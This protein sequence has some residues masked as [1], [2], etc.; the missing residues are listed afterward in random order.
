VKPVPRPWTGCCSKRRVSCETR[1]N[2]TDGPDERA[3]EGQKCERKQ[4]NEAWKEETKEV[5]S[6]S[7]VFGMVSAFKSRLND[8]NPNDEFDRNSGS[9]GKSC[10]A[11]IYLAHELN[12]RTRMMNVNRLTYRCGGIRGSFESR[13]TSR[14]ISI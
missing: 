2:Q 3:S 1:T 14:S 5:G 11:V 6:G 12:K 9:S 10:C 4:N 7:A 13:Q 8:N